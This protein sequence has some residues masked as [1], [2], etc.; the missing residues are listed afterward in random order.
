MT[1]PV[2]PGEFSPAFDD[3]YTAQD[4]TPD[5]P[6]MAQICAPADWGC[7]PEG[8]VEGL[9]PDLRAKAE[10]L[11]WMTLRSLTAYQVGD[12]PITVR[13]CAEGCGDD[14]RTWSEAVVTGSQFAGWVGPRDSM[15]SPRVIGDGLWVNVS[16]GCRTRCSCTFVPEVILPGPVGR[17]DEVI[18]DGVILD[19]SAYRVDNGNRLVRTDGGNWPRCQDMAADC[20]DPGSFCVTYVRGMAPDT[21]ACW[22]VGL[23]AYEYAKACSGVG[24]RLPSSVTNVARQGLTFEI[25]SEAF[26]NGLTGIREVD[27]YVRALNPHH[28]SAPPTVS[29]IDRRGPRTTTWQGAYS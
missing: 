26:E 3:A 8:Y 18:V 11:A 29:S 19:S 24:C 10:A 21:I 22:M 27:A 17:V 23:L 16:C 4:V 12:C 1:P 6:M 13:P 25:S 9:D 14:I 7:A 2:T 5:V 15:L 28:L 20:G